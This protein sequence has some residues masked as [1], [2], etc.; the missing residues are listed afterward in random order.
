MPLVFGRDRLC[1]K[2]KGKGFIGRRGEDAKLY[3][4][5][6]G[7]SCVKCAGRGYVSDQR[8]ELPPKVTIRDEKGG[9]V[10][11]DVT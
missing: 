9:T 4:E 11:V 1:K 8:Y 3:G 6:E 7:H 5:P 2:C 10:V